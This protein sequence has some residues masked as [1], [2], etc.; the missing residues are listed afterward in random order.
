MRTPGFWCTS[1]PVVSNS[2]ILYA[3]WHVQGL[4]AD[5]HYHNKTGWTW[6]SVYPGS[7]L[8]VISRSPLY[9]PMQKCFIL[10]AANYLQ[11]CCFWTKTCKLIC[12]YPDLEQGLSQCSHSHVTGTMYI[13][14]GFLHA[15]AFRPQN[16]KTSTEC[17][18]PTDI[19]QLKS[20]PPCAGQWCT[21]YGSVPLNWCTT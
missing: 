19:R 20:R 13:C 2:C 9:Q 8:K 21:T 4:G 7:I 5:V 6:V 1:T 14:G 3:K 15:E 18:R 11:T 16:S 17:P 10:S 12:W